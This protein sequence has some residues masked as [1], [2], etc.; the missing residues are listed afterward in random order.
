MLEYIFM[1]RSVWRTWGLQT[2]LTPQS[3]PEKFES[4]SA[5]KIRILTDLGNSWYTREMQIN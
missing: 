1:K 4:D 5:W 3:L 2:I